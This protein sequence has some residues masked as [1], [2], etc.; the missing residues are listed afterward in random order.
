MFIVENF[1]NTKKYA[2]L[3]STRHHPR[4]TTYEFLL[5]FYTYLYSWIIIT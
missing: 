2:K 4:S 5:D 3:K 1:L